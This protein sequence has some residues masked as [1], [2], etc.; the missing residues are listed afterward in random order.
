MAEALKGGCM[1]GAVRFSAVPEK[2]EMGVCHCSKCRRWSGGTFMAVG[3]ETVDFEDESQ[4]KVFESS[5]WGE[6]LFCNTCGSTLLWR[7]KTG[8]HFALSVQAF[9][10]PGAFKFTSQIFVDEKPDTYAFADETINMTGAEFFASFAPP[11]SK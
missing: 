9:D 10:D 6:R 2:M 8:E 1:C 7:M 3:C 4:L 11:E 5:D